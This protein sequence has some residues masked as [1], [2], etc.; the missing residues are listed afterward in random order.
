MSAAAEHTAASGEALTFWRWLK[1][2]D[3]YI[4]PTS[5]LNYPLS[6]AMFVA[7]VAVSTFALDWLFPESGLF[8]KEGEGR[9]LADSIVPPVFAGC[10]AAAT[11]F[12]AM[13]NN[14]RAAIL[15]CPL[16]LLAGLLFLAGMV[17]AFAVSGFFVEG[18]GA[19][20]F[21][22]LPALLAGL[23]PVIACVL[24]TAWLFR[25]PAPVVRPQPPAALEMIADLCIS[26]SAGAAAA[27]GFVLV[28]GWTEP[29][30]CAFPLGAGMLGFLAVL[31]SGLFVTQAWRRAGP[32]RGALIRQW[33]VG[34]LIVL[35]AVPLGH[36]FGCDA[37]TAT[38]SM[39]GKGPRDVLFAAFGG[40]ALPVYLA[41]GML[42]AWRMDR[43]LRRHGLRRQDWV[44]EEAERAG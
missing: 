32:L 21:V 2:W 16:A 22:L 8:E 13:P 15:A 14:W 1:D 23:L 29:V 36:L 6:I 41:A 27:F 7:T 39:E 30:D 17:G 44:E 20:P 33:G 5:L 12:I 19:S 43:F 34:L 10:F 42:A 31:Y 4:R 28:H 24:G 35:A 40:Y 37:V 38:Y 25:S 26:L 18:L 9:R 3:S 11:V